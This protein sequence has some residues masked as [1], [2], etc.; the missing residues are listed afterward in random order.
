MLR[1]ALVNNPGLRIPLGCDALL[2]VSASRPIVIQPYDNAN[3]IALPT[4]L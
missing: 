2:T 3:A 4:D 1:I